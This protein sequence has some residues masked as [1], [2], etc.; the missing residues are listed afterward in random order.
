MAETGSS[1]R[2][3]STDC[4]IYFMGLY[5]SPPFNPYAKIYIDS[6]LTVKGALP[7]LSNLGRS[8][9]TPARVAFVRRA[10]H[11]SSRSLRVHNYPYNLRGGVA[12]VATF[13][14]FWRT[15]ERA[16]ALWFRCIHAS[17]LGRNSKRP[18]IQFVRRV[19]DVGM[20]RALHPLA[21]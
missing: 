18:G 12:Y 21:P 5:F 20:L 4:R 7:Y 3:P 14:P 8:A 2:H 16:G 17:A 1:F 19:A 11:L 15:R 10:R 13:V 6:A 9:S